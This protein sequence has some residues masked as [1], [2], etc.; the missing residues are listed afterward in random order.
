MNG[1]QNKFIAVNLLGLTS[2][3][4]PTSYVG[5]GFW[6]KNPAG[7]FASNLAAGRVSMFDGSNQIYQELTYGQVG[8]GSSWSQGKLTFDCIAFSSATYLA[9]GLTIRGVSDNGWTEES[10]N[11]VFDGKWMHLYFEVDYTRGSQGSLSDESPFDP[12]SYIRMYLNGIP[13]TTATIDTPEG[14]LNV[15]NGSSFGGGSSSSSIMFPNNDRFWI[16]QD[17]VYDDVRVYCKDA[18]SAEQ[19]AEL[20]SARAYEPA[21]PETGGLGFETAWMCP[22]LN[23]TQSGSPVDL[24]DGAPIQNTTSGVIWE[25]DTEYGGSYRVTNDD[26]ERSMPDILGNP[27]GAQ[28]RFGWSGWIKTSSN[29]TNRTGTYQMMYGGDGLDS[30]RVRYGFSK[31][32]LNNALTSMTLKLNLD[33]VVNGGSEGA[34]CELKLV[35]L[36]SSHSEAEWDALWNDQ[37]NHWFF[38]VDMGRGSSGAGTDYSPFATDPWWKVYL[39]GVYIGD[40]TAGG[41]DAN[42]ASGFGGGT[43]SSYLW[44]ASCIQ[45]M[46]TSGQAYDDVRYFAQNL[47]T[48]TQ[49][50]GLASERGFSESE[51]EP[52]APG[53]G[54][55][56]LPS[57]ETTNIGTSTITD[58]G[59]NEIPISIASLNVP[60]WTANADDGG[61]Q[62]VTNFTGQYNASG[63]SDQMIGTKQSYSSWIYFPSDWLSV[64]ANNWMFVGGIS[65]SGAN[66]EV[67]M[68]FIPDLWNPAGYALRVKIQSFCNDATGFGGGYCYI[69]G[70]DTASTNDAAGAVEIQE[71]W[72]GWK[73]VAF[74]FDYDKSSTT[75]GDPDCIGEI[76]IDGIKETQ[77]S[78]V[79]QNSGDIS[80]YDLTSCKL[81]AGAAYDIGNLST[82]VNTTWDD[83]RF[84]PHHI[85]TQEE[86]TA[87]GVSR[88]V[89]YGDTPDPEPPADGFYNPFSSYTFQ[90]IMGN[91]IR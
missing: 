16:D 65:Q 85:L 21:P 3:S 30:W 22:S 59:T 33:F 13:V 19:I 82:K 51:P 37:W 40:A 91:R 78:L 48:D 11:A 70:E 57:S 66:S 73:H 9:Q 26:A 54:A 71:R 28:E 7:A 8:S 67:S 38:D 1:A 47:P 43:P 50:A 89:G 81:T 20:A 80:T 62:M 61:S 35:Y 58:R 72:S 56:L 53:S 23:P 4:D 87:L 27:A 79:G 32:T 77:S 5:T 36:P 42:T 17:M 6:I 64:S 34:L 63:T 86:V 10:W 45:G 55:W 49:I 88:G 15:S 69:I 68:A 46:G 84:F 90:T 44:P 75:I 18:P 29:Q 14:I 24:V 76:F 83:F 60:T 39:N 74:T 2:Q 52:P 12:D 25:S 31:L 41:F